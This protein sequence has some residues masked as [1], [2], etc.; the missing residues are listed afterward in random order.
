M[1]K[2]ENYRWG[3][4][5]DLLTLLQNHVSIPD[6][7]RPKQLVAAQLIMLP[8][9]EDLDQKVALLGN[10]KEKAPP[11][12]AGLSCYPHTRKLACREDRTMRLKLS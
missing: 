8:L 9:I 2:R 11:A 3:T 7:G 10:A 1:S 4:R 6:Q 12:T 5:R